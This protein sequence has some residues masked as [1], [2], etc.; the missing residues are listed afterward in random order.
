MSEER[1]I[2]K[3]KKIKTCIKKKYK[4]V[5]LLLLFCLFWLHW[6]SVAAPGLSPAVVSGGYSPVAVPLLLT[7]V[8]SL[9]VEHNPKVSRLGSCGAPA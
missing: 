5:S 2:I 4:A 8:A 3:L 9:A 1:G 7:V 6:T